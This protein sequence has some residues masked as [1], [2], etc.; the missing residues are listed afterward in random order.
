MS[1]TKVIFRIWPKKQGGEVIA[2]FPGIAGT[3]GRPD[4]CEAYQHLGQHAA[5]TLSLTRHC[6]LATPAQYKE[7]A[8]E[9]RRIG[10]SLKIC[11]RATRAD[12]LKRVEQLKR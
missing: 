9:L 5:A 6:K 7:L 8:G 11:K 3:V 4:T 2:L 1:K 10:Y 12:Y